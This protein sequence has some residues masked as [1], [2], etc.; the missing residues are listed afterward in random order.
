MKQGYIITKKRAIEKTIAR[1]GNSRTLDLSD[2]EYDSESM[3]LCQC[4]EHKTSKYVNLRHF[5]KGESCGCDVCVSIL[6]RNNDKEKF[7]AKMTKMYGDSYTFDKLNYVDWK[8]PGIITC[9]KHGDFEL[10]QIRY[11]FDNIP[12]P[13][14][15][16]ENKKANRN[17]E[18]LKRLN[19]KYGD[20]YKWITTDFGDYRRDYVEFICPK[21]GLVKQTLTVLLNTEDEDGYACPKCRKERQNIRQSY[22]LTDAISKAKTIENCK[23][24]DFRYVTEWLGVKHKYKFVCSKHGCEFEQ[25][26][27][28][29]LNNQANACP[30]CYAEYIRGRDSLTKDEFIEKAII[31]HGKKFDY[32]KVDYVNYNTPVCIICPK[33]GEFWQTPMSHL[34]GSGCPKCHNSRLETKVRTILEDNHIEYIQEKSL[35]DLTG[36][37]LGD[38]P[39]R[40]DFF[41]PKHNICIECQGLQHF[42]PVKFNNKMPDELCINNYNK[43]VPLDK[44]KYEA[45]TEE[46]YNIVYFT[47]PEYMIQGESRWYNDKIV[48]FD[49]EELL[50]YILQNDNVIQREWYNHPKY[51]LKKNNR[52]VKKT[53]WNKETCFEEAKKYKSRTE[54][55]KKNQTAYK[56]ARINDWLNDYTWFIELRH[57]W[58]YEECF[59]EAR[60]YNSSAE[61][62]GKNKKVHRVAER[63]GWLKDYYWFIVRHKPSGYWNYERCFE[64]AKKYNTRTEFEKGGKGAY[65]RSFKEKWIDDYTWFAPV[66]KR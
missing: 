11:A 58:T 40:I 35:R 31:V 64:E 48:F 54:F 60:K 21:H 65:N 49:V 62:K 39:Q 23:Y 44:F 50:N 5:L 3:V 52:T 10:P 47:K 24:Y 55:S 36:K 20:K 63:R 33:H 26:F 19:E 4:N 8:S 16:E 18:Y 27:D 2:S 30:Q 37:M 38:T 51:I 42:K 13:T 34:A 43:C 7:I 61:F 14:C 9:K 41:I 1:Y 17:E 28:S 15:Y 12:C 46:K 6:K 32:S 59:N 56:Y 53:I 22:T 25:S 66:N 29:L 57:K 45:L